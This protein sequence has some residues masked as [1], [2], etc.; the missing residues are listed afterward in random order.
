MAQ[1][2]LI[3]RFLFEGLGIRGQWV[4]L[5]HS[6]QIARA[7][8]K[9]PVAAQHQLGQALAAVALLASTIKFKGSL[10][11]QTQGS[12]AIKTLVAQ[13]THDRKI[14]GLVHCDDLET[15][16]GSLFGNGQLILTICGDNAHP[17][18]GIVPLESDNLATAIET[19]FTQSEQ[20][21]TRLW[22][23]AD[24]NQAVGLL[25]QALPGQAN[26]DENWQRVNILAKTITPGELLE[27]D[28]ETLLYRLFNEEQ[29]RLFDP[30]PIGFDCSC[31][32]EKI[33][34]MLRLMGRPE[35]ESILAE[36]GK[37]EVNC[38]FC[39]N[40]YQFDKVDIENLLQWQKNM[41]GD[42]QTRH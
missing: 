26:G 7:L 37:I 35:L 25:L 39:N 19:Y 9:S 31:S 20:L 8:Q 13:A 32:R 34:T 4:K 14:R 5:T 12:G 23:I 22:L 33:E 18:Q 16:S 11:L 1:H 21:E 6:W 41:P 2:D 36:Q 30:E 17:Y 15:G 42:N 38:E 27:L 29:V 24:A 40:H 10:I 28:C 3:R